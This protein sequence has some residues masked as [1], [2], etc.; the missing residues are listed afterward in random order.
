MAINLGNLFHKKHFT[1]NMHKRATGNIGENIACNFIQARGF[2]VVE[3]NYLKKWGELDIIATKDRII[4]FFEVKSVT[5]TFKGLDHGHKPED[6][7]HGLKA[8]RL[9]RIIETYLEEKG[10]GLGVE[11]Y[12]HVLC[13]FMDMETRRAHV[14]W[15]KNVIL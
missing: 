4:H 1:C 11:F 5:E 2:A 9:R 14:N 6:N 10:G 12:F 3:R 15:I 8:K 13:V 7:V